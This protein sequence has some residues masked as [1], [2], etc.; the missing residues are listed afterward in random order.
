MQERL[1]SR[2]CSFVDEDS[3]LK[4]RCGA[5]TERK[6]TQNELT[7][8][9]KIQQRYQNVAGPWL[10]VHQWALVVGLS[11]HFTQFVSIHLQGVTC[12]RNAERAFASRCALVLIW[13]LTSSRLACVRRCAFSCC[14]AAEHS[15]RLRN[16]HLLSGLCTCPTA[17]GA[18]FGMP[19]TGFC[20]S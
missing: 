16:G 10:V 11:C 14:S 19:K 3:L 7:I 5:W 9:T 20:R 1:Y 8:S 2:V 18:H 6:H 15:P 17:V 12:L 13:L 4:W